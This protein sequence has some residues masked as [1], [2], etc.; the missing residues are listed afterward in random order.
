MHEHS[1]GSSPTPPGAIEFELTDLGDAR[2]A[3]DDLPPGV[4]EREQLEPGYWE[5]R[6]R[7]ALPSDRALTGAAIDWLMTLPAEVR[8]HALC[9]QFPRVANVIADAWIDVQAGNRLFDR[10]LRDDR[11]GR[12]GFPPAV[13][14]E[15]RRL[16]E[17]RVRRAR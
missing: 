12:R 13:E 1:P 8:P 2:Q 11:G 14:Q 6:R 9:E 10:L 15:L 5:Q 16:A 4:R 3:L 7:R 17:F